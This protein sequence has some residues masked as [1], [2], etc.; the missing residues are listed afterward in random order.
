LPPFQD[1]GCWMEAKRKGKAAGA[2][3]AHDPVSRDPS[4]Q[5]PT[6]PGAV[7]ARAVNEREGT[8]SLQ[9]SK[10]LLAQAIHPPLCGGLQQQARPNTRLNPA[11]HLARTFT[12]VHTPSAAGPLKCLLPSFHDPGKRY[13]GRVMMAKVSLSSYDG[14]TLFLTRGIFHHTE[15]TWGESRPWRWLNHWV[16]Q[17]SARPRLPPRRWPN[18]R[19]PRRRRY[20]RGIGIDLGR[21]ACSISP[22]P[23][24]RAASRTRRGSK[25][26]H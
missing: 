12:I 8:T 9:K 7:R 23:E 5:Q 19:P 16:S 21:P 1:V 17:R 25:I 22:H 20:G 4:Q 11:R 13:Q 14:N 10:G 3:Q 26:S 6:Q 2:I 15:T 18:L 24:A